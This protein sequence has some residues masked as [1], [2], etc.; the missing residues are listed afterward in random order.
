MCCCAGASS[1]LC[2]PHP[3]HKMHYKP[4]QALDAWTKH[5]ARY[6]TCLVEMVFYKLFL[7]NFYQCIISPLK[8]KKV[9]PG[10]LNI[11]LLC[12]GL[13]RVYA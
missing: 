8:K 3:S 7:P 2:R 4:F 12:Q 11:R 6:L 10:C 13:P 9:D 1:F 5:L